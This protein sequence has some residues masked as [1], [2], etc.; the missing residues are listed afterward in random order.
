MTSGVPQGA[1]DGESLAPRLSVVVVNWNGAAYVGDCLAS[2]RGAAREVI[3]V[4]N[5]SSDDSAAVVRRSAPDARWLAN[6]ANLGFARAANAGLAA[7]RGWAVLFLNPDARANP[8]AIEAALQILE[9]RP[10]VGLVSVALRDALGRIV[11]SVEPFF[12]FW[13]LARGRWERRVSAPA[14][15]GPIEIPWAHGAFYMARRADLLA[16]G[17]YDERFFLY[18]EDMDLCF[19]VHESGRAVVHL[20]QVSIVHDGNRAGSALGEHRPAVIFAS[21]LRFY[22]KHHGRP[23][24]LGLRAA[25][26]AAF[27]ARGLA[28]RLRGSPLAARYTL[29]AR[30]ALLGRTTAATDERTPAAIPAGARS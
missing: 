28:Y 1:T 16:L 12:G 4:D 21:C 13:T 17:G 27:A 8:E 11:P 18:A 14:G 10:E 29:L 23:A 19:R 30:A 5:G 22:E 24:Q 26:A 7:A 2:V 25:A 15:A 9:S 3:V 20:P 6:G